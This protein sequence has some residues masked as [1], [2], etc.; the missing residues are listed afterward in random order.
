MKI[1]KHLHSCLTI[2]EQ[3]KHLLFDPGI[4]T[5]QE[6]GL[7]ISSLKK[8]DFILITHEHHDHMFVPFIKELVQKFPRAVV[9][10]NSSVQNVLSAYNIS[11]TTAGNEIVT[12]EE[13]EHE[14][15]FGKTFQNYAFTIFDK[16]THPGDSLHFTKTAE[17]LALPI[18]APWGSY[19]QALEKAKE[20]KPKIVI[21]IHDWH[22]KDEARKQL[23]QRA[24]VYLKEFSIGFKGI[25]N[26]ETLE[27]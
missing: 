12:I 21:P 18:Q 17:I 15:V 6:H 3:E 2:E 5:Y 1:T 7:D 14:P 24:E 19:I 22:W 10:S 13:A 8:L 27:L 4:Y 11:V 16:L 20:I 9:I 23:Y 25:E 26:N